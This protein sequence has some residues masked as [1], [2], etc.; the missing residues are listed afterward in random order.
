VTPLEAAARTY[1]A[2]VAPER[3]AW[4]AYVAAVDAL[5]VARRVAGGCGGT[6]L[7]SPAVDAAAADVRRLAGVHR[8][9]AVRLRSARDGLCQAAL[10][11]GATVESGVK[12]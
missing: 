11:V 7:G 12:T 6:Q 1:A 8:R 4:Q 5:C 2:A 9:A 3:E 10:D